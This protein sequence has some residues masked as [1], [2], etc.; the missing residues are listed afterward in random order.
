MGDAPGDAPQ[1]PKCGV[2][3]RGEATA[4]PTCGLRVTRMAAYA[5]AAALEAVPEVV[6]RAV[7]EAWQRAIEGWNDAA[8]HEEL[9]QQVA[10]TDSYAWVAARYRQ[11]GPDVIAARQLA[12]LRCA[13]EATLLASA[14][15]HPDA[16]APPYRAT[17]RVLALLITTIAAGALYAMV[18]RDH[19]MPSD[20]GSIPARRLP[21]GHPVRPSTSK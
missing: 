16:T 14:T 3:Y 18:I 21:P 15:A 5:D 11:R 10:A 17:R 6:P 2:R 4:C 9:L 12:R 7:E 19:P 1:C 8:R 13:A 20:P